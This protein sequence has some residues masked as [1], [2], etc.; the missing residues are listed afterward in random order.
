MP[1]FDKLSA[2]I[3][4]KEIDFSISFDSGYGTA[5]QS[6]NREEVKELVKFLQEWLDKCS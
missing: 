6:L 2:E 1:S 4:E 3:E 5:Y